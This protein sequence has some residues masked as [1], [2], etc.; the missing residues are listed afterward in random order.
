M[1]RITRRC[2]PP[3]DPSP[4]SPLPGLR[5][6]AVAAR[7]SSGDRVLGQRWWRHGRT[8]K[9]QPTAENR[10]GRTAVTADPARSTSAQCHPFAL[11]R[12]PFALRRQHYV[13]SKHSTL[14]NDCRPI[15]VWLRPLG[16]WPRGRASHSP[17]VRC[18]LITRAG[19]VLTST[20]KDARGPSRT[21]PKRA[22]EL[23]FY[24]CS[25]GRI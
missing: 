25:G 1:N 20:T 21:T 12:H 11:R 10:L 6:L 13:C 4:P 5:S 23:G 16:Q 14:A 3:R 19:I 2:S 8:S 7:S 15:V 9:N 24:F 22:S 18:R 17:K